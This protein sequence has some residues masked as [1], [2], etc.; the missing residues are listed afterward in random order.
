MDIREDDFG[1]W[2]LRLVPEDV[3]SAMVSAHTPMDILPTF[4]VPDARSYQPSLQRLFGQPSQ[5]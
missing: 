5:G 4:Y 1:E 3:C 2:T